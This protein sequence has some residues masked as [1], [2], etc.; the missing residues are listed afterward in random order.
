MNRT[1]VLLVPTLTEVEWKIRALIEEWAEVASFDAPGVG[2][3][4]AGGAFD[5][6]AIIARG[7]EEIERRGWERCVIVG[8]E[9]GAAQAV[10]IA[11]ARPAATRALVLGHATLTFRREGS[12]RAL[13][14]DLFDA[15]VQLAHADYRSFVRALSQLTQ[16]AYDDQLAERY[17]ERVSQE[18]AL[19]YLEHLLPRAATESL[20]PILRSLDVPLLLVEHR[21][22]LGWTAEGYQDAVAAFPD[23]MTGS[24]EIKASCD[25]RFA[26]LIR[27]FCEALSEP[28]GTPAA[29]LA[30]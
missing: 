19:A 6:E 25:P 9:A 27:E 18:V 21:G 8:D 29:E 13:N 3:E 5:P 14:G 12:R 23:A 7:V 28:S 16:Q 11:A 10:H 15:L 17:M 20:E 1:R 22:C 24:V 2:S 30:S 26:E 4:P